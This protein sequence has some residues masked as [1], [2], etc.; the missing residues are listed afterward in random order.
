M[1]NGLFRL[2]GQYRDRDALRGK[3]V[4]DPYVE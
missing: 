3:E 1:A 2:V 4:L